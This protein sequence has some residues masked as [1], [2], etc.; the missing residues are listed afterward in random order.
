MEQ[1]TA[2][3]FQSL[4]RR[5]DPLTM[6]R[7]R[8]LTRSAVIAAASALFVVAGA[9]TAALAFGG[10]QAVPAVGQAPAVDVAAAPAPSA[11]ENSAPAKARAASLAQTAT[12]LQAERAAAAAKKAAAAKAAAAKRAAAARAAAAKKAAATKAA[13]STAAEP[14]RAASAASAR[15]SGKTITLGRYVY[16]PGSQS[17]IDKCQ[18]V[19][20]WTKPMWL[21]AHNYCG[22]QWLAFVPT[23]TTVV[24]PSG[25]AAGTYEVTGHK[26]L[27][28][29]SGS[30]PRVD[31]DLVLQT[32]VGSGTGLT[33]LQRV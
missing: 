24:V 26:R 25:K 19:L 5:V 22:Y 23:G 20:W 7:T 17:A 33:L 30:L 9:G 29:Q 13:A 14:A 27:T 16:A 15:P 8:H 3:G 10:P 2:P 1:R 31:A 6:A 12:A 28:R 11:A 32:C 4:G 18:L 21:A